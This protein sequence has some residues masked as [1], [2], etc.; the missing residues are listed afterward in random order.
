MDFVL[1]LTNLMSWSW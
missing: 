1:A